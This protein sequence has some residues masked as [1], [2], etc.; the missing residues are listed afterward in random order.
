MLEILLY[1]TK[2]T[3]QQVCFKTGIKLQR[4]N[5]ILGG[6]KP[7]LEEWIKIAEALNVSVSLFLPVV[8]KKERR[9]RSSLK[10]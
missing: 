8:K 3:R 2:Q 10:C 7:T 5:N 4:F 9:K 1:A 6:K